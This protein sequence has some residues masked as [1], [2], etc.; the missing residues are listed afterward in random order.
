M[1]ALVGRPLARLHR[2][3]FANLV[4]EEEGAA[5]GMELPCGHC[6]ELTD[7]EVM[8]IYSLADAAAAA[9]AE[10]PQG[11]TKTTLLL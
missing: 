3:A 8:E 4:T 10:R 1:L 6:R 5:G 11:T 7:C 2:V 9:A